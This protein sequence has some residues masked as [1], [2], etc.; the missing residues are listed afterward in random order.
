MFKMK[1]GLL[2]LAFA[3]LVIS[4]C[5]GRPGLPVPVRQEEET[6]REYRWSEWKKKDV[7][8]VFDQNTEECIKRITRYVRQCDCYD[9]DELVESAVNPQNCPP[10]DDGNGTLLVHTEYCS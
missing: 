4:I 5:E 10:D 8:E 3:F 9:G 6:A 2:T 1:L 7:L